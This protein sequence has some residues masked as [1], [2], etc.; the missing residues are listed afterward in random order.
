MP[1]SSR[2]RSRPASRSSASRTVDGRGSSR[3]ELR[4]SHGEVLA[5]S[6]VVA[7]GAF[8]VPR[9]PPAAG[10]LASRVR[11]AACARLPTPVRPAARRRARRRQWPDGRAARRGAVRGGSRGGHLG[12]A[13]RPG[14]ATVPRP[15]LLPLAAG[16]DRRMAPTSTA[17][18]RASSGCRTLARRL[19]CNPH[20]SGHGGGHD[21]N[22]REFAMRGIR[23]AGRFEG[24]DGE[25]VRFAAD[26]ER[27]SPTPTPCSTSASATSSIDISNEPGSTPRPM[28]GSR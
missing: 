1:R 9:I 22:L 8:H 10:S 25:R 14:A 12:R 24:A 13:L 28:T 7:T 2:R 23:L 3:F 21:T 11:R 27:T 18:S 26:S 20:L 5:R 4:T 15:R 17:R 16:P 6:V 19:A